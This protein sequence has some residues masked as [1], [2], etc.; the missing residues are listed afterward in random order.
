MKDKSN[1]RPSEFSLFLASDAVLGALESIFELTGD[2]PSTVEEEERTR[3]L[4]ALTGLAWSGRQAARDM[5][6]FLH[7]ASDKH[8]FP[9]TYD[10]LEPEGDDSDGVNDTRGVYLVSARR[11]ENKK[12]GREAPFHFVHF[13]C[14][15]GPDGHSPV[16]VATP[17]IY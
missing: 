17:Y 11:Q 8:R 14:G 5:N 13:R 10:D 2:V 3:W 7:E 16:S 1:Q 9:T 12:R 15:K 4:N 6:D